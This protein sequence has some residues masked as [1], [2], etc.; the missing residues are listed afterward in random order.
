MSLN[1]SDNASIGK[2]LLR[3][4]VL[5]IKNETKYINFFEE[6]LSKPGLDL[7]I[8]IVIIQCKTYF[9]YLKKIN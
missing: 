8:A 9:I 3:S 1:Y 4:A 6:N 2:Y 7:I 5:N